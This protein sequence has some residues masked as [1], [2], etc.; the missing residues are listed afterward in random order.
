[1][2][3]GKFDLQLKTLLG[4]TLRLTDT[5]VTQT[6]HYHYYGVSLNA[7][8]SVAYTGVKVTEENY[9]SIPLA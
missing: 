3:R 5:I 8:S 1:L 6:T 2:G 4:L 9:R 7:I